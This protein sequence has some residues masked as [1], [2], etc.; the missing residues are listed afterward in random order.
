MYY[1]ILQSTFYSI[2]RITFTVYY[3]SFFY[4]FENYYSVLSN[5]DI[6]L[7]SPAA[8]ADKEAH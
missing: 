7:K 5:D 2:M 8:I 4:L 1:K 3:E 6:F